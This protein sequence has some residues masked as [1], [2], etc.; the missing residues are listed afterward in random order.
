MLGPDLILYDLVFG[1]WIYHTMQDSTLH[2]LTVG[3]VF[4]SLQMADNFQAGR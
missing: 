3:D 2:E 1:T 4:N